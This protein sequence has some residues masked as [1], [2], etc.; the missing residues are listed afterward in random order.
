MIVNLN[1]YNQPNCWLLLCKN[2]YECIKKKFSINGKKIP[3]IYNWFSHTYIIYIQYGLLYTRQK[4]YSPKAQ[5]W[6]ALPNFIKSQAIGMQEAHYLPP[7]EA[8]TYS[9][10]CTSPK[11]RTTYLVSTAVQ[12]IV[13]VLCLQVSLVG[14]F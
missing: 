12:Y 1:F 11:I 10:Y 8:T 4:I 2:W 7:H 13:G 14:F 9:T 5:T 6:W 3:Q